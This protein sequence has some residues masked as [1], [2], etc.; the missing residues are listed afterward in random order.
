MEKL[1]YFNIIKKTDGTNFHEETF[2]NQKGDLYFELKITLPSQNKHITV[3]L[4]NI[5]NVIHCLFFEH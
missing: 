2:S 4:K 3:R 5:N 1:V